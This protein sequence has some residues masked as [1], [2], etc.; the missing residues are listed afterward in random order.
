[1][2][3]I[4]SCLDAT[5]TLFYDVLAAICCL[6]ASREVRAGSSSIVTIAVVSIVSVALR[7]WWEDR[8]DPGSTL[9]VSLV[10]FCKLLLFFRND[11]CVA[12]S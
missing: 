1:M 10:C 9:V 7:R 3:L 5:S 6:T 8:D 2:T 11:Y 12:W 4:G